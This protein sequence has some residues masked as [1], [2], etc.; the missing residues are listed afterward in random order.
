MMSVSKLSAAAA[1]S[2]EIATVSKTTL[3]NVNR[4]DELFFTLPIRFIN[5]IKQ[6]TNDIHD[7]VC[8]EQFLEKKQSKK[9][10]KG[11]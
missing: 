8:T 7:A 1:V 11:F 6:E 9:E 5:E 3:L 10:M 2:I 4:F